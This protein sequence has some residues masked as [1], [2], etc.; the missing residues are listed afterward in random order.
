M[1]LV[2]SEGGESS[3]AIT[4]TLFALSLPS[5]VTALILVKFGRF[6]LAWFTIALSVV[7][8]EAGALVAFASLSR[9]TASI[10]VHLW[11]LR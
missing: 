4:M 8:L 2:M 3:L 6:Y 5:F 9:N 7:L 10:L 11:D 1:A